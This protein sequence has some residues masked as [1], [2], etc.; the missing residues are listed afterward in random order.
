MTQGDR[1]DLPV[2]LANNTN[3]SL[4]V[5]H[6]SFKTPDGVHAFDPAEQP[7]IDRAA[8]Y[9]IKPGT[10]QRALLA[11]DVDDFVGEAS[12]TLSADTV[13][14]NNSTSLHDQVK[15]TF[16]VQP[17][18]FP[19]Q[20]ARGGVLDADTT[21]THKISI[22]D[23]LVPGSLQASVEVHPTPLSNMTNSLKGMI[24]EP[25]GCFEQTSSSTYPL[26]MAQQYFMTHAEVNPELIARSKEM[27]DKGYNR[28]IGFECGEKGYE[29]FG[30]DPMH[31]G[32]TAYGLLEFSDM[33]EVRHVDPQMMER[34]R[35]RLLNARKGDGNFKVVKHAL[36]T[37]IPDQ[38]LLNAYVTWALLKSGES[39]ETL[40]PEI[41]QVLANAPSSENSYIHALAAN[42]ASLAGRK[43][44]AAQLMKT[45]AQSQRD[46]GENAGMVEGGTQT[47]VG[48]Q[49]NALNIET[50][51]LATLAWLRDANHTA[52]VERSVK[53]L[54]EQCKGGRYG[55][56]QST[57][58]ALRAIVQYDKQRARPNQPGML[59]LSVDGKAVG[60]PI[61]FDAD[62]KGS[63][64]L[65]DVTSRLTSGQHVIELEMM[66]GA[67]MPYSMSIK[68]HRMQPDS[69]EECPL[70]LNVSL[71]DNQLR[72][73]EV[74]EAHVKVHHNG[75]DTVS[76]PTAIIGIPGGLEV[77]HDQL[78]ELVKAGRIAAY[79]VIGREVVLYWRAMDADQ[80][81][82]LP[83][84]LVAAVPGRYTGPA[85]RAYLYY[86]DE[87]KQWVPGLHVTIQT[88]Q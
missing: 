36:H 2:A 24:R 47:I 63:I 62:T 19:V 30:Q 67:R 21:V 64:T 87:H 5:S 54:A 59:Q 33:S 58:L 61:A 84:S 85:S 44:K 42:I 69:S 68:L 32:L 81:I 31:P 18:G 56:T 53:W 86:G 22:P 65:P 23:D 41:D 17:R 77:R 4:Q 80:T 75:K 14:S 83:L 82:E 15:R 66:D 43:D 45:L 35:Q 11:I 39:S 27:L 49:G 79:E 37:W 12:L 3:S 9:N 76:M 46:A 8:T 74:T 50:T 73:G 60:E 57:V 6:L 48:S 88:H 72:E 1:I 29:W 70:R 26:V 28:L 55:S 51:A 13:A 34:T 7:K 10:Q 16:I 40:K 20:I 25:H 38:D 52:N 78:K 71:A